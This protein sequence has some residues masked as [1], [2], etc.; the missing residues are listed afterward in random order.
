MSLHTA[1]PDLWPF[2]LTAKDIA[3]IFGCSERS[4][5]R[6]IAAGTCGA[7]IEIDGRRFV[8]RDVFS[9]ALRD[10]ERVPTRAG[11]KSRFRKRRR[12]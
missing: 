8:R 3:E 10:R 11:P 12:R 5:Q 6:K 1:S 4:A 2:L 9:A 7:F